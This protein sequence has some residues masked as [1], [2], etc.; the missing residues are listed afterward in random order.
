MHQTGHPHTHE[1]H[2]HPGLFHERD[3]PIARDYGARSFTIGIG[4]PVGSGKT[5]LMLAL[6]QALRD[7]RLGV[8]TNDI[9]TRDAEFLVRHGDDDAGSAP[10]KLAA[11]RT[12]P[13]AK[14]SATIWHSKS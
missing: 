7:S 12:Q 6:C 10:S 13:S 11:A 5:A 9:F 2:E 4:G 8:V 3:V 1:H 14:T